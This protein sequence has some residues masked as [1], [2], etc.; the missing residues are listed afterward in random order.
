MVRSVTP[1]GPKL[2]LGRPRWHHAYLG[3]LLT[4]DILRIGSMGAMVR[5]R[6]AHFF[7]ISN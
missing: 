6:F 2:L 5:P 4:G 7:D 3:S 1:L